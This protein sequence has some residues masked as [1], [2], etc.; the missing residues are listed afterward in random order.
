MVRARVRKHL[1]NLQRRFPLLADTKILTLLGRDYSYRLI[2]PKPVW[3]EVL[4]EMAEEQTWANF[5]NEAAAWK[6]DTGADYVKKLHTV[7]WEMFQLQ[8]P[9]THRREF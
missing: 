2:V 6:A 5:K 1:T 3:V 7:W 4:K 9:E 8:E